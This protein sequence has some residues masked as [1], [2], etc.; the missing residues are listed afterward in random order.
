MDAALLEQSAVPHI[1]LLGRPGLR[2][3][4]PAIQFLNNR[5]VLHART[6]FVDFDEPERKRHL[7]RLWLTA[8][9][10]WAD[11]DTFVQQGIPVKAGVAS[12]A[13][14]IARVSQTDGV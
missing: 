1:A 7:L 8:H 10:E 3:Q 11:G 2:P 6:E 5:V 9:G 13:E 14:E 4:A 12:D